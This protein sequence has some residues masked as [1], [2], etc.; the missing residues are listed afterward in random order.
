VA[1]SETRVVSSERESHVFFFEISFFFFFGLRTIKFFSRLSK[2]YYSCVFLGD[3][4][5][6]GVHVREGF[7]EKG[8]YFNEHN[9]TRCFTK[10]KSREKL[11]LVSKSS[12]FVG[13]I[14]EE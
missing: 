9:T 10:K 7:C 1:E 13:I 5:T 2:L 8:V 4:I 12:F 11:F 6:C 3:F 14:A